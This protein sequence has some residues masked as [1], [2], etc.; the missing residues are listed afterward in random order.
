MA[1]IF[2]LNF[3]P[4]LSSRTYKDLDSIAQEKTQHSI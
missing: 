1:R 2:H 3:I 4:R